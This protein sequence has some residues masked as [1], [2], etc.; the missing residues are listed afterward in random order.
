M[1]VNTLLYFHEPIFNPNDEDGN[2]W[3]GL[4]TLGL[5]RT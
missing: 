3:F 4:R 1:S 2:R 5:K